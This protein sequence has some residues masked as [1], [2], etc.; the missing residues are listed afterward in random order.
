MLAHISDI[1][2]GCS[3]RR[4]HHIFESSNVNFSLS[5]LLLQ[6]SYLR[7][8]FTILAS[9][10]VIVLLSSIRLIEIY[11]VILLVYFK[12]YYFTVNYHFCQRLNSKLSNQS[13]VYLF[14]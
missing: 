7:R 1:R 14:T 2:R 5:A 4:T 11:L 9:F 3:V 10:L 6:D 13:Q 8:L 12:A